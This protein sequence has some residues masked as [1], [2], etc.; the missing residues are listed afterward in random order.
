[1]K[2]KA[3]NNRLIWILAL[4]M[5][6]SLQIG[7]HISYGWILK[8][9]SVALLFGAYLVLNH[10]CIK[11][12]CKTFYI[13]LLCFWLFSFLSVL[14][15]VEPN[16]AFD[17]S[18]EIL[19]VCIFTSIIALCYQDA[20]SIDPFLKLIMWLG[21]MITI[22]VLIY[23]GT[24]NLSNILTARQR[25]SND[26]INANTLGMMC[27]YSI[28][29]NMYYIVKEKRLPTYSI[30]SVLS[31]IMIA[32][33]S[34]KKA[35]IVLIGGLFGF[36]IMKNHAERNQIKKL[37]WIVALSIVI[38]GLIFAL[39]YLPIF[40][41]MA[42]RFRLLLN[43]FTGRGNTD[44]S[45]R[46]RSELVEIG[47]GLF[48]SR[49][50]LGVGMDNAKIYGGIAFSFSEYYLHNNYAE[51]LADGGIVGLITYYSMYLYF[52]FSFIK[53]RNLKDDEY[54]MCVV[55][56]ATQLIIDYAM[57]SYDDRVVFLM[58]LMFYIKILMMK[59]EKYEVKV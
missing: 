34:S 7:G 25:I 23:Y 39:S 26:S 11:V 50:F 20:N 56:F 24:G 58:S 40:S 14:W 43:Y 31:V 41:N 42:N 8:L 6:F 12:K 32:L 21:Y 4:L 18:L 45:T 35:F 54:I 48:K 37:L 3:E 15:A 16:F 27:A 10:M 52:L 55:L 17:K 9:L 28:L 49:P 38:I 57:V 36:I 44:F 5:Y 51:L 29:I 47:I 33:S 46:A 59:K 13:Y 2:I 19:R 22:Y 30:L 53:Y 1:M